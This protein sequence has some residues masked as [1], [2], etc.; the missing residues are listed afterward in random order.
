M[1]ACVCVSCTCAQLPSFSRSLIHNLKKEIHLSRLR[2]REAACLFLND[3]VFRRVSLE[4]FYE[5]VNSSVGFIAQ[6]FGSECLFAADVYC[7]R[8]RRTRDRHSQS[9]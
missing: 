8:F 3:F 6:V 5:N 2:S 1:R 7:D 4:V 9:V